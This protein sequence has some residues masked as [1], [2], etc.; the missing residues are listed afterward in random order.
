MR[1]DIELRT[2]EG[3]RVSLQDYE[4]RTLLIVNVASRCGFTPQYQG[5]EALHRRYR[6]QGF[7]V[8]G[9]P[10]NQFGAQE[11]GNAQQI[12]EFCS[13]RY[14]VSFPIFE[15]IDVNGSGRHP[16]YAELVGAA[17]SSGKSGD[18][19]WNFEKFLV[20]PGGKL[21]RFR[22]L[23]EPESPDIVNSIEAALA[24]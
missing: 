6:D 5:L 11:P 15:K 3:E 2:L 7:S 24:R 20:S 4:D 23:V 10:C 17:D 9:F 12:R 14:D 18:V 8:L 22:A 16:L 1:Y 21:Q 13:T 19:S